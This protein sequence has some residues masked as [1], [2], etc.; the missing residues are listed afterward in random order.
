M[1][2]VTKSLVAAS[3]LG[4]LAGALQA[5]NIALASIGYSYADL[6]DGLTGQGG[7]VGYDINIPLDGE[8]IPFKGL[9]VGFGF[10]FDAYGLNSD[11]TNNISSSTA[12]G[13]NLEATLG[14]RITKDLTAKAGLGYE[15]ISLGDSV[16]LAGMQYS[17]S[18]VYQIGES[19]GVEAIYTGG[20][21]TLLPGDQSYNT[22]KIGA[23][24]VW[25]F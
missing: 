9:V 11:S 22:S 14:Y 13:A 16:A 2:L 19:W 12:A 6:G 24:I 23:N 5:D 20:N 1:K 17:G 7:S 21:L 8:S 15:Y 25:G 10:G 3:L 18:L 4:A